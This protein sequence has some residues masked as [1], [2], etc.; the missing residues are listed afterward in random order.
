MAQKNSKLI[1]DEQAKEY[2]RWRDS[3]LMYEEVMLEQLTFDLIVANPYKELYQLLQ[4]LHQDRN[5]AIRHAAWTFCN[6][7]C[8]TALP[9]LMD[10]RE[11]AI[12]SIFFGSN[13]TGEPI[14]DVDGQPWWKFVDGNEDLII[15]AVQV[16]KDFYIENPL[17]KENNPYNRS[18]DFSLQNTR[19]APSANATPR[20]DHDTASPGGARVNGGPIGA[21]AESQN[22]KES[23]SSSTTAAEEASRNAPGDSDAA[24]KEAANDPATHAGHNE[25]SNG[26]VS[27]RPA[28]RRD[29]E[30]WADEERDTKR[31]RVS[32]EM[33][34]GDEGEVRE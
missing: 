31:R 23:N 20:T 21:A 9:L 18:P 16:A 32:D 3:I 33:D 8:L 10:A 25:E 13:F 26:L 5:K 7:A 2:W 34:D 11:I 17:R 22:L 4:Q 29:E 12:A 14:G 15:K 19:G 6:D 30:G 1:I 27:P 28:K 24:L